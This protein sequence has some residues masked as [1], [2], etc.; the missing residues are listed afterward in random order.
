[1]SLNLGVLASLLPGLRGLRAP[2]SAG[3]LWLVAAWLAFADVIP[4][5]GQTKTGL[6]ND[7]YYLGEAAGTTV[8]LAAT[9]FVAY[10][11][12]L[13]S[14]LATATAVPMVRGLRRRQMLFGRLRPGVAVPSAVGRHALREAVLDQLNERYEKKD[15]DLARRLEDT[16]VVCGELRPMTDVDARRALLAVRFDVESYAHAAEEE[17][18][19]LPL[20]LLGMATEREVYG[21]F[22]QLR[23]EA[24]FRAA[25]ALPLTAVI[26]VLA[27]RGNPWALLAILVPILLFID[28]VHSA[29]AAADVLAEAVRARGLTSTALNRVR[30]QP[31]RER[32][33]WLERAAGLGYPG[34]MER[35]A[36][37][38]AK[39]DEDAAERWFRK[40]AD[41]GNT[42]AMF[43][44]AGVLYRRGDPEAEKWYA[45]AAAAGQEDAVELSHLTDFSP[46]EI[47]DLR[48]AHAGDAE[49][50]TR[51]G[52]SFEARDDIVKAEAWYRR[53]FDAGYQP[54]AEAMVASLRRRGRDAAADQWMRSV[55]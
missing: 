44:L 22:D 32:A 54:A 40:A 20:R 35:L 45:D 16:R 34:A 23:A 51:V 50:M 15:D 39:D 9:T 30:E 36:E 14:L 41:N 12:G 46:A 7:I 29:S 47:A 3:Y 37:T 52:R 49:A 17:L 48:S 28:A 19:L 5:P 38:L 8:A 24:E 25:V 42:S 1:M 2:L 55:P 26:G 27:W 4:R 18:T 33:D 13:L 31:L 21:E 43:H 10:L 6:V 53:G 11:V